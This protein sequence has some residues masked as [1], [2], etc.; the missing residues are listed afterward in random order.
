MTKMPF[1]GGG[2]SGF[3]FPLLVRKLSPEHYCSKIPLG[4]HMG[5]LRQFF[6]LINIIWSCSSRVV[7]GG[8][9]VSNK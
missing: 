8:D 6:P 4:K 7:Q 5:F 3:S 9:Y 2:K 1:V